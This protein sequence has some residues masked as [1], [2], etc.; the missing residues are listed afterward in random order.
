M[1]ALPAILIIVGSVLYY[2][3][4]LRR[5][6]SLGFR[7]FSLF[8]AAA[9]LFAWWIWKDEQRLATLATQGEIIKATIVSKEKVKGS[10]SPSNAVT[11]TWNDAAGSEVVRQTSEYVSD[12]EWT[13]FKEKDTL[14]IVREP[15][16]G[17]VFVVQSLNRFRSDKW[18]LYVVDGFFFL[19]G[20]GCWF[21]LRKHMV[22]VNDAGQEWVEKDGKVVL[23]GRQ[24]TV[25]NNVTTTNVIYKLLS[26]FDS[27]K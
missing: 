27:K 2:L 1:P 5:Y 14:D 15:K 24:D 17:E 18:I 8:A 9:L 7:L 3:F 16:S 21:F 11:L 10:G 26:L 23:D 22:L 25:V 4:V 6:N 19:L 12:P 13:S 20:C